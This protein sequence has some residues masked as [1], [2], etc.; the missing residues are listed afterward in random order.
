MDDNLPEHIRDFKLETRFLGN[1]QI[2]HILSDANTSSLSPKVAETWTREK[3]FIGRGGQGRVILQT[4][5]SGSRVGAQRAVKI[6]PFHP[7]S[8]RRRYIAELKT[9]IK[10]SHDKVKIL[11]AVYDQA[12]I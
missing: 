2:A 12:L 3:R 4:C 11:F 10:F 5:T 6:I 7:G 8:K 9:N 1:G